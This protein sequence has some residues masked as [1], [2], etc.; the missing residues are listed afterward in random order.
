MMAGLGGSAAMV[1]AGV[2]ATL[3]DRPTKSNA[4]YVGF[5]IGG[6]VVGALGSV[7]LPWV[8]Q[9]TPSFGYTFVTGLFYGMAG[10]G[11]GGL[12]GPKDLTAPWLGGSIGLGTAAV[13]RGVL[14]FAGEDDYVGGAAAQ[15]TLGL[16]GT[17]GCGLDAIFVPGT[18]RWV[19]VGCGGVSLLAAIH[20][21]VMLGKPDR[22]QRA[23]PRRRAGVRAV[24]VPWFQKDA[25]GL[26]LA[27]V[28]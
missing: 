4:P 10:V 21:G 18:E 25:G 27:G 9:G 26:A 12:A 19:A 1:Y 11:I 5:T 17:V 7:Y 20:G 28:F 3:V 15:L 6:G 24:P 14:S 2:T 16:L 13:Y 8:D 23:A 22:P